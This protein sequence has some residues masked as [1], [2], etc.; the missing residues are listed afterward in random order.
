MKKSLNKKQK[1]DIILGI[2]AITT[3]VLSF[4]ITLNIHP[5]LKNEEV[6]LEKQE[7]EYVQNDVSSNFIFEESLETIAFTNDETEPINMHELEIGEKEETKV[8]EVF[9]PNNKLEFVWP[10]SGDIV[11][12]F[13]VDSLVFSNTLNEWCIHEGVDIAGNL[14]DDVLSAE[15]GKIKE[16]YDNG[17]YG[18]TVVIEHKDGYKSK[19]SFIDSELEVGKIVD[20]GEKIGVLSNPSNSETNEITHLHFELLKNEEKLSPKLEIKY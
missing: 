10:I 1:E 11:K 7:Y 20:K 6:V 8:V 5:R 16:V 15:S 4:F 14:G 2:C 3:G 9:V 18:F 12:D 13:V 19:Y 17:K